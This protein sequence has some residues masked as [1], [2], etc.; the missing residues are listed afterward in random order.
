M[1][2]INPKFDRTRKFPEKLYAVA[3]DPNIDFIRWSATGK[4]I[5][6]NEKEF[7]SRIM[8]V[9]PGLVQSDA[10]DNF[11]RQLREYQFEC[12]YIN[13]PFQYDYE[14]IHPQFQYQREDLLHMVKTRRRVMRLS[15]SALE[16]DPSPP[17]KQRRGSLMYA[18]RRSSNCGNPN[19][20]FHHQGMS[21][22]PVQPC[23]HGSQWQYPGGYGGGDAPCGGGGGMYHPH[24]T[25]TNCNHHHWP[26]PHQQHGFACNHMGCSGNSA[27]PDNSNC[28]TSSEEDHQAANAVVKEVA[29][30]Q[31]WQLSS[32][33]AQQQQGQQ[34][35]Y[36]ATPQTMLAAANW[37]QNQ[38]ASGITVNQAQG[39][40]MTV[41]GEENQNAAAAVT[42]AI[43]NDDGSGTSPA[44]NLAEANAQAA[45][46]QRDSGEAG[47]TESG[48]GAEIA[49]QLLQHQDESQSH[50]KQEK[51]DENG[52]DGKGEP[53]RGHLI[54]LPLMDA[55]SSGAITVQLQQIQSLEAGRPYGGLQQHKPTTLSN[56]GLVQPLGTIYTQ[57]E[58][59]GGDQ[60]ATIQLQQPDTL[61]QHL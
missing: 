39:E 49:Q 56:M 31:G 28:P 22:S 30:A 2:P 24:S 11:R 19:C 14:F 61:P 46:K 6:V 47:L 33:N 58:N 43:N 52:H 12:R 9:C 10:F 44:K 48:N 5:I 34:I 38:P 4:A 17:R 53:E 23:S 13:M 27:S 45:E 15:Q 55:A 41:E 40:A 50:V 16:D 32:Q 3:C 42:T 51:Q 57:L 59:G 20:H 54:Q 7:E 21:P 26:N 60:L 29:S 37:Y 18:R 35:W 8:D 36:A 25:P 1:K